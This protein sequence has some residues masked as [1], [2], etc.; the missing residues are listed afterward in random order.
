MTQQTNEAAVQKSVTV[1]CSAERA[2]RVFTEDVG[3][4]WPFEKI[5]SVAEA[6]VETVII[7][8]RAGGRFYERTK[9][10]EEH[11]W[12]SVLVWDPPRRL[13]STWHPGRGDEASQQLE[14]TF[15]PDGDATRVDL[16]HTGWERLGDRMAEAVASYDNGWETVLARY[17]EAANAERS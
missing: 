4:W 3:S 15:T 9:S 6:D 5:H 8:G 17:V 7:E 16:V 1:E 14:I 13:V 12:G 11:L 10:G 2:F